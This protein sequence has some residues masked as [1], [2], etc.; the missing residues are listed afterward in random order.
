MNDNNSTILPAS[1]NANQ[2]MWNT[3]TTSKVMENKTIVYTSEVMGSMMKMID[4]VAPSQANILVLG[5]SGTG[6]ELIARSIH[7]RSGRKNKPFVAIN[8]GALRETLLESELFGHEK[9]SFTGAYN[10]KI[11]LAEAAT[12]GTLFL[13]E[14]GELDPAIQA[15]LL[16]FIQEGEIFRVG[17]K[18]PIKVDIRLICATNRELDQEVTRGNFRED[19]FYRINTIVVSAPPLRRRKE[20]IPSLV[21]HF[22]NNSQHAYLNR[23]RSVSE[24]AM[25]A[26][27]KY[28]WPGNIRELQNVCERL[29]ILS[30][31]HMIMLNDVPEN[32]RNP[33]TQK[34]AID[35]DPNMTL[36][37]LEKRYILKALQ[38]FGGNK[39]QAANNLGITIKTLYNK[40]HEYG[41]F[42]KFA[43]HSKPMK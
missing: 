36:H 19:L 27:M 18:D 29:Q 43:V 17:G 25:K 5:E 33:E 28:D 39:T 10:R 34:D 41:E 32:I 31:G 12:G 8:C 2:V 9:G 24:D 3:N 1:Q 30:D 35:Y 4:R 42:E 26:L 40:L 16:R 6:K 20:D 14:I 7:E 22:L 13:D 37:D 38:H 11:G 23:G 21:N 15:K